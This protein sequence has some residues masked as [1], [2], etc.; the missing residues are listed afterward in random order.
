MTT[1]SYINL[2][3]YY[4]ITAWLDFAKPYSHSQHRRGTDKNHTGYICQVSGFS[5]GSASWNTARSIHLPHPTQAHTSPMGGGGRR[6]ERLS[7]AH[8][9][10]HS[11]AGPQ[12]LQALKPGASGRSQKSSVLGISLTCQ[13]RQGTIEKEK[14]IN[15]SPQ[16]LTRKR[17]QYGNSV[18]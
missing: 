4:F 3:E 1:V 15:T 12:A 5:W 7:W 13:A 2:H 9:F 16:L 6:G 8:T 17:Q 10:S 18:F 14:E 11:C